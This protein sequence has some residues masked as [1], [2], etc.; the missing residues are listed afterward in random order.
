MLVLQGYSDIA[1]RNLSVFLIVSLLLT[2][3]TVTGLAEN[4][5]NHTV[6]LNVGRTDYTAN[7]IQKE[8]DTAPF[9]KDGRTFVPVRFVAE[10]FNMQAD[11]GP[12]ESL[13]EWVTFKSSDLEISLSI[14][15]STI[16]VNKNGNEYTI[17][18]DV[19]PQIKEG[20][21]FL[22]LR[23]VGEILG[24]DFDW[25]PKDGITE[26][27]EF[28]TKLENGDTQQ[29]EEDEEKKENIFQAQTLAEIEDALD[30]ESVDTIELIDDVEGN[31]VVRRPV[32]IDFSSYL[33]DGNVLF[34]HEQD[35]YSKLLSETDSESISGNLTINTPNASFVNNVSIGGSIFVRAV[36]SNSYTEN[37][38]GNSI[39]IYVKGATITI[40]GNSADVQ[41]TNLAGEIIIIVAEGANVTLNIHGSSEEVTLI[42]GKNSTVTLTG[43]GADN[44]KTEGEGEI[45]IKKDTQS[46]T[47]DNIDDDESD[48][49]PPSQKELDDDKKQN[50]II[51]FS[52]TENRRFVKIQVYTN[53]LRTQKEGSVLSSDR[54]GE[55]QKILENGNYWFTASLDGYEDY[56]GR[57]TI[58]GN[59]KTKSYTM[60]TLPTEG[61]IS[62]TIV[63]TNVTKN[64]LPARASGQNVLPAK[65]SDRIE[66]AEVEWK[67]SDNDNYLVGFK[68]SPVLPAKE[69]A[70]NVIEIEGDVYFETK[71]SDV[72]G[73]TISEND[74]KEL[75]NNPAVEY[76]EP[77]YKVTALEIEVDVSAASSQTVSWGL[78]R[79][80]GE[81]TFPFPTWDIPSQGSVSV[82]VLDSGIDQ[83]H[84]NLPTLL[85]GTTTV[86]ETHWGSDIDGHGTHVAGVIAGLNN[87]IGNVG[88]APGANMYSVK[89]LDDSG[90][91]SIS[92]VVDGI[93]WAMG[94]NIPIISMSLVAEEE[95]TTLTNKCLDAYANGHLLIVAAGNEGAEGDNTVQHPAAL[96]TT[97]AVSSSNNSDEKSFTSS[98][99]PQVEIMAPGET[100]YS[101]LPG[102]NYGNYTGTSIAA[103]HVVG[104]AILAWEANPGLTRNQIRDLLGQTAEDIGLVSNYQGQGLVRADLVIQEAAGVPVSNATITFEAH[105]ESFTITSTTDEEGAYLI[106]GIEPGTYNI[107]LQVDGYYNETAEDIAVVAGKTTNNVDYHLYLE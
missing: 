7:G 104:A 57:F 64:V 49:R 18:S 15:V 96:S 77:D 33:F 26:W 87:N 50:N 85:G 89:V 79:I 56:Q 93:D 97:I 21:T 103:P 98:S 19:P 62:G 31:L 23:A 91:G 83:T 95:S 67:T 102:G 42:A 48:A 3:F 27:V 20:R 12:K 6:R 81:E 30:D 11:W 35:V 63:A 107:I 70:E 45:N 22:P 66:S 47:N 17:A 73:V 71:C 76:V 59:S 75:L 28:K 14:G 38:D 1:K 84:P 92:T 68:S 10:E 2:A 36:K 74:A 60:S 44:V 13:T 72:V 94:Q 37:A 8:A 55:A 43:N 86:D 82:A 78:N 80:F 5:E 51:T 69:E 101:T 53:H 99:G 39:V 4:M 25:G 40:N 100:I 41:V 54:D 52:E 34:Q 90:E 46:D 106:E 16:N 88:V 61:A 65:V 24:T 29:P 32:T 58:S 9:I 105:D